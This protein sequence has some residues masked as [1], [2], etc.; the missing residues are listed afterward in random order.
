MIP[1]FIGGGP[2]SVLGRGAIFSPKRLKQ[3][4]IYTKNNQKQTPLRYCFSDFILNSY[5]F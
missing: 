4:N 5:L 3:S 1:L 2:F